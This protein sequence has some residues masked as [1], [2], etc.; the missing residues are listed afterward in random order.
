MT[1]QTTRQGV[2]KLIFCWICAMFGAAACAPGLAVAQEFSLGKSPAPGLQGSSPRMGLPGGAGMP[3]SHGPGLGAG[4]SGSSTG[5]R[6]G[7]GLP[8]SGHGDTTYPKARPGNLQSS[9]SSQGGRGGRAGQISTGAPQ[10][11]GK[12]AATFASK[13]RKKAAAAAVAAP[14]TRSKYDYSYGA[15]Q[16]GADSKSLY[17][18]RWKNPADGYQW[19]ARP[20]R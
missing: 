20:D 6:S 15:E 3:T 19:G 7:V 9:R 4:S 16:T 18:A 13:L 1:S 17:G 2:T 10:S 5:A 12:Q 8:S 14:S 11:A